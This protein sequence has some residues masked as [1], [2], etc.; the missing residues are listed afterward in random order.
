MTS[1]VNPSTAAP[2]FHRPHDR[3]ERWHLQRELPLRSINSRFKSSRSP[4]RYQD[5]EPPWPRNLDFVDRDEELKQI[6]QM[7]RPQ[8]GPRSECVVT[9]MAGTGKTQLALEYTY[10]Y[11]SKYK[12][13]L[14]LSCDQ[15]MSAS[16]RVGEGSLIII[17]SAASDT[18]SPKWRRCFDML[19][20]HNLSILL[21][22]RS[23]QGTPQVKL[24]GLPEE[25]AV[26]WLDTALPANAQGWHSASLAA[27]CHMMRCLPFPLQVIRGVLRRGYRSPPE[28]LDRVQELGPRS[29]L[30]REIERDPSLS[31]CPLEALPLAL[32]V[33]A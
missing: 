33:L 19:P 32:E 31:Y 5:G 15:E 3:R 24:D 30:K 12:H 16:P 7:L 22:T 6:W 11:S 23:L 25:H 4:E 20:D 2:V 17:D 27:L 13:C 21:T 18:D 29:W 9:G 26:K 8:R 10:R 14:W 1:L 28:V